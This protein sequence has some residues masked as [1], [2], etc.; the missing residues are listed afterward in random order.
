[1]Q[2]NI[3]LAGLVACEE[4][5]GLGPGPSRLPQIGGAGA[6]DPDLMMICP[7]HTLAVG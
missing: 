7:I 1:M 6:T 5:E 3:P 2:R 4:I